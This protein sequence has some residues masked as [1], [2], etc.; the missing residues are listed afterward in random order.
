MRN[1]DRERDIDCFLISIIGEVVEQLSKSTNTTS[2]NKIILKK[3]DWAEVA[4]AEADILAHMNTDHKET[5]KLYG[6]KLLRKNGI[7]WSLIGI[8]PDGFDL[9]CGSG[10]HRVNFDEIN[11]SVKMYKNT[12]VALSKLARNF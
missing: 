12:L 8:D 1:G 5:L 7:N 3:Q 11:D 2:L 10:I 6:T 4:D 9:R